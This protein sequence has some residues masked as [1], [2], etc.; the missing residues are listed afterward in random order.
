[1]VRCMLN[2]TAA[3]IKLFRSSEIENEGGA[4][5]ILFINFLNS[6]ES[7]ILW[8]YATIRITVVPHVSCFLR[9]NLLVFIITIVLI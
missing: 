2:T 1:M 6:S 9:M 4:D 7:D 5:Q 3:Q 8:E